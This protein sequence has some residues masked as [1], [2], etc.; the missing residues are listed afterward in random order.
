ME[1]K[2]QLE[3]GFRITNLVLLESNF[4]RES[5]VTFN[6]TE[7]KQD[8]N[9]EVGVNLLDN[10]VFVTET[11]KFSQVFNDVTEVSATIKM[12]GVFEKFGETQLDLE[13]FGQVN[14]A[15]IIF[16]YVREHLT[17]LSAK[18]GL[19]LIFLPPANFTKKI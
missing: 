2:N 15:A 12:I 10:N 11:V 6:N 3:S 14:G 9:V 7:I 17:N 1:N 4:V 8:I 13:E 5:N 18:A 16:P 19:G